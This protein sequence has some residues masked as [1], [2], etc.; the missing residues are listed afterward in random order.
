M[1]TNDTIALRRVLARIMG[2]SEDGKVYL[3]EDAPANL[4]INIHRAL[5]ASAEKPPVDPAVKES[6]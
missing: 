2:D 1:H 4:I 5:D 3:S 6:E